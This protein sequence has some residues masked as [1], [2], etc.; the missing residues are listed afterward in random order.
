MSKTIS[1]IAQNKQKADQAKAKDA[2]EK[3]E[4][5]RKKIAPLSALIAA[6]LVFLSLDARGIDAVH[7]ITGSW[8]LAAVTVAVSG[9]MGP[10]G[11]QPDKPVGTV[12]VAYG[13]ANKILTQKLHFRFD[14]TR[15]I[16]L[17][18]VTALNLLRKF[19]LEEVN[20]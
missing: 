3:K 10:D 17:T 20:S 5:T 1:D 13:N 6:N 19:I 18:A 9:I 15:N 7:I 2:I 12:W 16:Q 4:L 14:R 11:G 8:F